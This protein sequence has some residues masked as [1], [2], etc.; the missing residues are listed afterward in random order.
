MIGSGYGLKL[1]FGPWM[2]G[3]QGVEALQVF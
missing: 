1:L 2:A 3:S